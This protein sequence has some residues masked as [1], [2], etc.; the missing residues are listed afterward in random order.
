[1]GAALI[2]AAVI[3]VIAAGAAGAAGVF[4]GWGGLGSS[5][6]E[7][8]T[9]AVAVRPLHP[10]CDADAVLAVAARSLVCV[11]P[12]V[13]D[14]EACVADLAHRLESDRI[15]CHLDQLDSV[16]FELAPIDVDTIAQID[17]EPLLEQLD[18]ERQQQFEQQQEAEQVAMAAEAERRRTKVPENMQ[19]IEVAKPDVEVAPDRT[20][21]VS[22]YDVKVDRQTVAHGSSHEPMVARPAPSQLE[23]KDHPRDPS[24]AEAQPDGPAG[25]P[26]A[27]IAPGPLS[28]RAPG[29]EH[30]DP[31]QLAH[32]AGMYGGSDAP[33]GDGARARR[34]DGLIT[35]ERRELSEL[36]RGD[37]GAGGG[38]L[39][40]LRPSKDVLERAVGGGAVDFLDDVEEGEETA[41][42]SRQWVYAS[43]FNRV[44][45]RVH[46]NWDPVTVWRRHDP[47]GAVYGY[48]TRVTRLRITLS[49]TGGVRKIIV[50]GASGVELLDEEAIR[51]F[52]AAQPFPNPPPGLLGESGEITF[53]FGFHLEIGGARS[54]WRIFRAL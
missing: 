9:P 8:A 15:G 47:T 53:D 49:P 6:P 25:K 14:R 2:A 5:E 4:R 11:S 28:M 44:K 48:Q 27:P 35:S 45:R 42:N 24:V 13:S 7:P 31:P 33:L 10:T 26:G 20:R 36:Q 41:L 30:P 1:V 18:P 40:D 17:P 38:V 46:E 50:V 19:V 43:F 52:K 16:A 12:L 51:A 3:H 37:G 22:E 32:Q 34:G 29:T 54:E 39:P 21:F 23:V